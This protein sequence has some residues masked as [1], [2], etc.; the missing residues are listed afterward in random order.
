VGSD[1]Y[2]QCRT[3]IRNNQ[4][5]TNMSNSSILAE[6]GQ[7]LAN[8]ATTPL[9]SRNRI[10]N[11]ACNIAQRMAMAYTFGVA[12]YGGPDRYYAANESTAANGQFTQSQGTI[13]YNGVMYQAV[14]QTVNTPIVTNATT[15]YWSGITQRIEGLNCYDLLGQPVALSFIFET[16]FSGLYSVALT[17]GTQ[18]NSWVTTINAVAGIPLKVMIPVSMLPTTLSIPSTTSVGLYLY[19]GASNY[20][21]Y[22]TSVLNTWETGNYFTASGAADWG[23]TAGNYIAATQIQL[24]P[25]TIATRFEKRPVS[26]EFV[27]CYRYYY[28]GMP[29]SLGLNWNAYATGAYMSWP[30]KFPVVM[31]TIPTLGMNIPG[32]TYANCGNLNITQ[33]T[34]TEAFRFI[35]QATTTTLNATVS[36]ALTDYIWASAEL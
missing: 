18:L 20:G 36:F 33:E 5:I 10:I 21:T 24:E 17:D 4:G 11:G 19:I 6:N 1:G 13:T 16:N 25:G 23:L 15:N 14:T 2:V 22:Q 28:Q 27:N 31:R 9:G 8:I 34:N 35:L 12:G 3:L 7:V 30:G 29:V 32:V 26:Q